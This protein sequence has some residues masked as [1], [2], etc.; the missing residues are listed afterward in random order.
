[1]NKPNAGTT[2]PREAAGASEVAV[3]LCVNV[4]PALL[5]RLEH[6]SG[7][8]RGEVRSNES[9]A[10]SSSPLARAYRRKCCACSQACSVGR[11]SARTTTAARQALRESA[12]SRY[13]PPQKADRTCSQLHSTGAA[14]SK[15]IAA[16]ANAWRGVLME[17][18]SKSTAPVRACNKSRREDGGVGGET[19]GAGCR[20]VG[21][22]S[23]QFGVRFHPP[24]LEG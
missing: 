17:A 21:E 4:R 9:V 12:R 15:S 23:V 5:R 10:P 2:A 13:T 11:P 19:E 18:K 7:N 24:L 16:T 1:M 20:I 3:R 6:P 8:P 14:S 22:E